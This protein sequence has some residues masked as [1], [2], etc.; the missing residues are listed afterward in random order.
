[1]LWAAL[2][3]CGVASARRGAPP[4]ALRRE[5]VFRWANGSSARSVRVPARGVAET[6]EASKCEQVWLDG[7]RRGRIC[8]TAA[9]VESETD[10]WLSYSRR[11]FRKQVR[12]LPPPITPNERAAL[13]WFRTGD[14]EAPIEPLHGVA[15]HPRAKVGCAG[16][17]GDLYDLTYLV[18]YDRCGVNTPRPHVVLFDLGAS[19]RGFRN[20][21]PGLL[22]ETGGR[23]GASTPF[24]KTLYERRCLAPDRIFAWEPRADRRTWYGDLSQAERARIR[25]YPKAVDAV[26]FLSI[27][28]VM[29]PADF[30]IVKI[31]V[32]APGVEMAI[33]HAIAEGP[34]ATR[35]DELYFEYHF[36]FDD[37]LNFGWYDPARRHAKQ[38]VGDVDSAL[39]LMRRLRELGV[40]SHFWI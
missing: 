17:T 13:S 32:D 31:D 25:L 7:K 11:A 22:A 24:L 4:P 39:G 36:H 20:A 26:A 14:A 33:V 3:C 30:V 5:A 23:D 29:A 9:A 2:A 6:Y 34:L 21:T 35:V 8:A 27:L 28:E 12:A 10:D 1:M 16:N 19:T 15:R 37:G 40:R 18:P 38:L